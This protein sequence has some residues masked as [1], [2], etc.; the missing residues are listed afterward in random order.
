MVYCAKPNDYS[1]FSNLAQ[2]QGRRYSL[3]GGPRPPWI[4]GKIF[5]MVIFNVQLALKKKKKN[6]RHH[7]SLLAYYQLT[8]AILDPNKFMANW[9][10]SEPLP[11]LLFISIQNRGE[12]KMMDL[13]LTKVIKRHRE[14]KES[15]SKMKNMM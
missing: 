9:A 13:S 4:F 7:W 1:H 2:L 15:E 5:S 10:L 6:F 14:R 3:A 12:N 11:R 8:L